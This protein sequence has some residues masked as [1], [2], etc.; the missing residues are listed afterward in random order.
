MQQRKE[1]IEG[2]GQTLVWPAEDMGVVREQRHRSVVSPAVVETDF[3]ELEDGSLV[4]A[5]EDPENSSRTLLAIY[6]NG[7]VSFTD[8]FRYGNRVLIPI[9]RGQ[10][11]IRHIR[12]PRGVKPYC[13][14][15]SLF[16]PNR[17]YPVSMFGSSQA[18]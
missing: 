10:H 17:L 4:E 3:T 8:R 14:I 16:C 7:E 5:I 9:P 6:K 18:L 13:S 15:A 11:I 1:I 12:L 2:S